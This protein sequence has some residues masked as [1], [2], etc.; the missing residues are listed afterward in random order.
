MKHKKQFLIGQVIMAI[1]VIVATLILLRPGS[2]FDI[3]E[4]WY[5][6][7]LIILA[8]VVYSTIV[9]AGAKEK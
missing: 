9:I 3:T 1:S 7:F 6:L 8:P 4:N 5:A 2:N